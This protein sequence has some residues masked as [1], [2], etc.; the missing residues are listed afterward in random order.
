MLNHIT[1]YDPVLQDNHNT[2]LLTLLSS[3]LV[4]ISA[5]SV[6]AKLGCHT[7]G[8][9][10]EVQFV[11]QVQKIPVAFLTTIWFAAVGPELSEVL[12]L[13]TRFLN[14]QHLSLKLL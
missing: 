7:T 1:A 8:V 4:F 5:E 3:R 2:W 13:V 9:F 14:Q 10:W 12:C 11:P 6:K